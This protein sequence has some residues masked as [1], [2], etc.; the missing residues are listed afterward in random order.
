MEHHEGSLKGEA[1]LMM[2]DELLKCST[3]KNHY[4]RKKIHEKNLSFEYY[5]ERSSPL[6]GNSNGTKT[7]AKD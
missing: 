5:N 3:H 2:F 7:G 1:P 6:S 4:F